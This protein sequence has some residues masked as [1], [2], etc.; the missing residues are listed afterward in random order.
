[1]NNQLVINNWTRHATTVNS[2]R[3][4]LVAGERYDI[5]MEYFEDTGSAV[6]RLE[7]Q[8]ATVPRQVIPTSQLFSAAAPPLAIFARRLFG[9][10][11]GR[12]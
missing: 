10:S 11:Q 1:V 4:N 12:R 3:I 5:R 9:A 8:T 2:G 7:W 6:A